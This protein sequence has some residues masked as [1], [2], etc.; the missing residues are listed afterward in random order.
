VPFLWEEETMSRIVL[1]AAAAVAAALI[2]AGCGGSSTTNT[3][4]GGGG[5]ANQ[6]PAKAGG[7]MTV[8]LAEDPDLLDPTQARTFV[9]RIVFANM[10]EKLYDVNEK[11]QIVPQLAASMPK[12]SNG[13]KTVTI[14]IRP[15]LKFNDGTTMDAKAVKTSLD[16]HRTLET[17]ARASELE[18]VK[19]VKVVDSNTVRLSLDSL[20]APLTAQ[21]AD[22]S[23]MIMS[24]K[25]LSKLGDKFSDDPVCIGPFQYVSRKEGDQIVLKK[26]PDYYDASKVKLDR[27]VF[28]IIDESNARS[29]NLRSGDVNIAERLA[30]TDLA[31]IR[32]AS[33]LQLLN[34]T[35]LGYQGITINVGNKN[36]LGKPFKNVGTPLAQHKELRQALSLSLDRDAINKVVF[37]GNFVPGCGPLSPVSPYFDKSFK[38][39]ARDIAKAKQLVKQSGVPTPIPVKLM[40]NTDAVTL[41]LGQTIQAMAKEAG[42]N[43]QLQPTEFT[44]AL[45]KGDAG[46]FDTFQLGWSGRIDPD[47]NIQQFAGTTGSQNDSGYSNPALDKVLDQ[48]RTELDSARR[49]QIY[50][51]ATQMIMDDAPLIYIYHDVY[52]TGLGK[53]VTGF[54]FYGDGLLRLKEAG[55]TASS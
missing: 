43:V 36:G 44:S 33:N 51:Q 3:G 7:T 6:G 23:G 8:A 15:G 46:D 55:F 41:R 35:S 21:L 45:D 14:A 52:Y 50:K 54:K 37:Q 38:C 48:G 4:S 39:P 34:R 18:P 17:S 27:V 49:I 2:A 19:S 30:P 22:R 47:G 20:Y 53:N 9:G 26:A 16:R 25:Q 28:R 24:P 40:L 31:Q 1:W 32:A 5:T 13:G 29:A 42:F 10:C 11:L 12:I